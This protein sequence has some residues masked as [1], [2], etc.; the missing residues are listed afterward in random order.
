MAAN[1]DFSCLLPVEYS[2]AGESIGE[3][4]QLIVSGLLVGYSLCLLAIMN[5][6]RLDADVTISCLHGWVCW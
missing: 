2:E 5:A 3:Y 4:T 1:I 6:N